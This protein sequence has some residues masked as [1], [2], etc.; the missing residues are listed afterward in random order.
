M[1]RLLLSAL[2]VAAFVVP[3]TANAAKQIKNKAPILIDARLGYLLARVGP[4]LSDKGVAPTVV[5]TRID[6]VRGMLRTAYKKDANPLPK[7][8]DVAALIGG[9]RPFGTVPISQGEAGVFLT[10]LTP[11]EYVIAGT[12][13]TCFCMGSYRFTVRAGEITDIGTILTILPNE[14]TTI[15][16]FAG[17]QVSE[18]L[19]EKPYTMPDLMV[20][21]AATE[22]DQVPAMLASFP[23]ARAELTYTRFD[24]ASGWMVSRMTGLP[25]MEHETAE[26]AAAV[27]NPNVPMGTP[28]NRWPD[29]AEKSEKATAAK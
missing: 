26:A 27:T 2:A 9:A 12:E 22:T 21:H 8:E 28:G 23:R 15:P 13:S 5:V 4:A 19:A 7:G 14:A 17:Q 1:S 6:P 11:G 20:V 18:D 10:S 16:E 24:N 3:A 29:V 25:Q